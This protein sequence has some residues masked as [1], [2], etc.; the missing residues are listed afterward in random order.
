MLRKIAGADAVAKPR[1]GPKDKT[2]SPQPS[3]SPQA[4]RS[5]V[6][7]KKEEWS[8]M[9]PGTVLSR[10]AAVKKIYVRETVGLHTTWR[11]SCVWLT[12]LIFYS[13]PWLSLNGR[14][15]V[16]FDLEAQKFYMFGTPLWPQ[17]FIYLAALL[18]VF[19]GTLF[20]CTVLI[21]RV[22]CGFAC[23]HTVYTE[24]F[25]WIERKIEGGRNA[26][27]LL[28]N[29]P[30]SKQ[31]F[32][33]KML[34]HGV[35][36]VVAFWTGFTFAGYFTPI[37]VLLHELVAL[38]LGP[39]EMFWIFSYGVLTYSN[40]GWL[41]ERVCRQ[42]CVF[43]GL[44]NAL[45]GRATLRVTY[46]P[47]RGEPRG[48]RNR[49]SEVQNSLQGDCVDCTLCIQ[50]CPTG[51]DIRRGVQYD[52]VGCAACIDA[53]NRVMDRIGAPPGL[54]RYASSHAINQPL[55]TRDFRK[56]IWH[57][58]M[59]M[60]TGAL[61]TMIAAVAA[62]LA[63][64]VPLKLNV[65]RDRGDL[66]VAEGRM[67]ENV[68]RLHIMNT[69]ERARHYKIAV[70]GIETIRLATFEEVRLEGGSSRVV[71][72]RVRVVEGRGRGGSNEIVF[73]LQDRDDANLR[74]THKAVFL[75]P[76]T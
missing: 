1:N 49:K 68:Y 47:S 25:M 27:M 35:W 69:Q 39:W 57:P 34:K 64:R 31:K 12:Q 71:P 51:S 16:L 15:L 36:A 41:R 72:V 75:M 22:W 52:C 30:V 26:R 63:F 10:R 55:S 24:I 48:L 42:I 58:R 70:S 11:W 54:I 3:M 13:L 61:V 43:S 38:A 33:K 28:D 8:T 40:A 37:Q 66:R 32:K 9:Q 19:V 73:D 2:L 18:V 46:D 53:C 5:R 44:Q 6:A 76:R 4:E 17:D 45:Y 21:G 67:I 29:E 50:V 7:L 23:P 60:Y 65:I 62:S 59:L 56:R 20:L 74:V 14:Q